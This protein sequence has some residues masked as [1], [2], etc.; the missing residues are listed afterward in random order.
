MHRDRRGSARDP[1]VGPPIMVTCGHCEGLERQF[2]RR[3]AARDLRRFRRRGALSTTRVLID[4]LERAG[5]DGATIL[6]IGGGVGA[7]HH[8][9]LDAG[10]RDA[11]H[12]DVSGEY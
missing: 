3:T 6:D 1:A 11:T 5:I 4:S 8:V 7:V 9:L 2:G 12:V 10:A